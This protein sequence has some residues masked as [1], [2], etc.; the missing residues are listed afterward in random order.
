MNI[1][2][3]VKTSPL[4]RRGFRAGL[5]KLETLGSAILA[6]ETL[7]KETGCEAYFA[8]NV[9]AKALKAVCVDIEEATPLGRLFDM[10]VL[11]ESGVN[12]YTDVLSLD[13]YRKALEEQKARKANNIVAFSQKVEANTNVAASA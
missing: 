4:V 6:K 7:Y 9:D 5:K 8:V 12:P 3:P 2:G 1:A 11:D 13:E 10:D